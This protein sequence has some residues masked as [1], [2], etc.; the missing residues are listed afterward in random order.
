M[1]D[2]VI[3]IT[4]ASAGIGAC[5]AELVAKKGARPVLAARRASALEAVSARCEGRAISIVTD[6][7][8]RAE[9]DRLAAQTLEQLG[10]IDVW[11]NNAGR[12]I[13]RLV[14]ELTD[15]DLDEMYQMNV[16][17]VVYGMQAS[18]QSMKARG[19]GHI[20]N[21]S[22]MLG[23]VPLAPIRSAY[24]A[25]KHA[26]NA[27]SANLRMELAGTHPGIMVSVVHPGV[28]ATDFGNNSLHGG[29]DSRAF[30][31]AQS[32]EEVAQVI[33]ELIERP[34]A[35]VY[36]RPEAQRMVVGYYSAEDLGAAE[37]QPPFVAPA[38]P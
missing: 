3:V 24:S 26:M 29:P 35:D 28:V 1:R 20:I 37:R 6:V 5:L 19:S 34:R 15:A 27:L 31:N 16:K 33:A 17:S 8:S 36:T 32:P 2:R 12:G 21:I 13:S 11:V 14:S 25:S 7:R 9:V 4:G 23:R 30:A 22:S 38:R 18:L 10:A